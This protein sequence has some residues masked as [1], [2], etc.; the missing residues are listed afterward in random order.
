MRAVIE[1]GTPLVE[2]PARL[3]DVAGLGVD[4]HA[5]QRANAVRHTQ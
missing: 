4:E 3:D 2:D 1:V 5:W